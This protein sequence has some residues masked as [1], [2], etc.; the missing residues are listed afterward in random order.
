MRFPRSLSLNRRL[1]RKDKKKKKKSLNVYNT[2]GRTAEE[3]G[4]INDAYQSTLSFSF[5]TLLLT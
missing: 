4:K 5:Q 1:V 3:I 2:L